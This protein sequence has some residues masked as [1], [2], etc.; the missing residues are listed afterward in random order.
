M[1]IHNDILI[2]ITISLHLDPSW[3]QRACPLRKD[4]PIMLRIP[5][6]LL[7]PVPP[8]AIGSLICMRA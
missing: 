5:L 6:H 2:R 8:R 4:D 7:M 3:N 1:T